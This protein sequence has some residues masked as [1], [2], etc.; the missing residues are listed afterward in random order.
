MVITDQIIDQAFSDL[1]SQCGGVRNDYFGP[2]YLQRE[3]EIDRDQAITQVA[4]GGNDYEVDGFHFDR[5]RRNFYIFQFK[6]SE[7]HAQFRESFT[8][9]I[10]A[11]MDR[12]FGEKSQDQQHNQL[13]QQLK[14]CLTEN[15]AI[16]DR[17][18]EPYRFLANAYALVG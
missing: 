13:L 11:G 14:A 1:K 2:V 7:S 18:N 15:E 6:Y 5:D 9:L 17:R 3:F 8:R 10:D 12:L 4:F 16:I